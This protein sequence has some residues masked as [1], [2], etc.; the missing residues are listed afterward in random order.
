MAFDAARNKKP[1]NKF[2]LQTKNSYK[3]LKFK[4]ADKALV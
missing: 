1:E 2:I 3:Q 4:T